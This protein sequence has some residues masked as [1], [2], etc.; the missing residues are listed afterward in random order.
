[1]ANV[2]ISELNELTKSNEA[3]NDYL[4]IVDTSANETKK[5]SVESLIASNVELLAVVPVGGTAPEPDTPGTKYYSVNTN[6]IYTAT[7]GETWDTPETPIAGIFYI[8]ISEKTTYTYDEEN[9]TLISVGGGGGSQVVVY[10]DTPTEDTKLYIEESD[11]DFQGLDTL[12]D[13]YSTSEIKTNKKWIDGKSIYR[14]VVQLTAS[15][16]TQSFAVST[17]SS[18]IN[19][20]WIDMETSHYAGGGIISDWEVSGGRFKIVIDSGNVYY[21]C[22]SN[23][24]ANASITF[25]YT[26]TTTTNQTRSVN[27]DIETREDIVIEEPQE[28]DER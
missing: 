26:K 27:N 14:K 19:E 2:K 18:N 15:T 7:S 25:E 4:P 20:I 28:G 16:T 23:L 10:P 12:E 8:V 11:L 3:Y 9:E 22:S 17:I 5:I 13:I 1:M 6:K 24:Y 21:V